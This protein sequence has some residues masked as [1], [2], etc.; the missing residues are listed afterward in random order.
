MGRIR[1]LA[2]SDPLPMC[3]WHIA[4]LLGNTAVKADDADAHVAILFQM[5]DDESPLV[6]GW[7]I[8]SLAILGEKF[9]SRRP[10]IVRRLQALPGKSKAIEA[11]RRKALKT[12]RGIG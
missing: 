4:M 5:L 3:R 9:S 6:V 11:R 2:L 12:L 8:A 1:S 10:E 7:A